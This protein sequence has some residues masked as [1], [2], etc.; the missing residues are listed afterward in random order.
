MRAL[1]TALLLLPLLTAIVGE[2]RAQTP[3]A[4]VP[5]EAAQAAPSAR[6]AL[7][8]ASIYSVRGVPVEATADTTSKARDIAISRGQVEALRLLLR[9]LTLPEVWDQLPRVAAADVTA[10]LVG[11]G[12]AKERSSATRYLAELTADFRSN[13]IRGLLRDSGLPYAETQAQAVLVLPVY[14]QPAG[15]QLFENANPWRDAW[16]GLAERRDPGSLYPIQLPDGDPADAAV[17]SPQQAIEGDRL[18]LSALGERY[19]TE[20][21]LVATA[22]LEIDIERGGTPRLQ[23][24]ATR[25]GQGEPSTLI[26]TYNATGAETV[27]DLMRRAAGLITDEMELQWKRETVLRFDAEALLSVR[28]P[29]ADLSG[30]VELRRQLRAVPLVREL[31]IERLGRSDAQLRLHYLGDPEQLR[32]ALGQRGLTLAEELGY[33][34][35]RPRGAR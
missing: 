13:A 30:W 10:L 7:K 20:N 25:Y 5:A 12:L 18:R 9:R 17:L 8:S 27:D 24:N 32:V 23:V 16:L 35:L 31:E 19:G 11:I 21:L 29:I 26:D 15:R 6:Q 4:A 28:V 34:S 1:G 22:R 14:E 3:P 33:W 2:G